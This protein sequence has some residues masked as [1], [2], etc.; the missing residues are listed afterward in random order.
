T[1]HDPAHAVPAPD[2]AVSPKPTGVL[3]GSANE[4]PSFQRRRL[5]RSAH[6]HIAGEADD[7]AGVDLRLDALTRL[8]FEDDR[9]LVTHVPAVGIVVGQDLP[10]EPHLPVSDTLRVDLDVHGELAA[11]D[12][13]DRVG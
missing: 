11:S 3:G 8:A 7:E 4:P 9:D 12:R 10:V 5:A 6:D 13:P 2:G 1:E